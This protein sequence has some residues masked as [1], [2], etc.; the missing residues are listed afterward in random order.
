MVTNKHIFFTDGSVF[1]EYECG[2]FAA[3][4][5]SEDGTAHPERAIQGAIKSDDIQ[6]ME[7]LAI[8]EAVRS[9]PKKDE[10]E[11]F[12]D[13]KTIPDVLAKPKR[14]PCEKGKNRNLW[15][16]LRQLCIT[17]KIELHWVRSHAGN[18]ANETADQLA[19]AAARDL[20]SQNLCLLSR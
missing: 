5:V 4:P 17:R 13:H 10:V 14:A 2:G 18:M 15:N 1:R 8:I 7:L 20:I 11:I 19:R 16:Q 12:T 3:V 6:Q 9:V